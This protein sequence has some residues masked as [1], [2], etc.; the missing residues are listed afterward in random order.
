[1][2]LFETTINQLS[3]QFVGLYIIH[4]WRVWL[5][6]WIRQEWVD[7]SQN[8][9]YSAFLWPWIKKSS[10]RVPVGPNTSVHFI[11]NLV[12]FRVHP[13]NRNMSY[14]YG[15]RFRRDPPRRALATLTKFF[16]GYPHL[17]PVTTPCEVVWLCTVV[18]KTCLP[19]YEPSQ[20]WDELYAFPWYR[21]RVIPGLLK[22]LLPITLP[23][24]LVRL[25]T[26][27]L[28]GWSFYDFVKGSNSLLR[29]ICAGVPQGFPLSYTPSTPMTSP[30]SLTTSGR[31]KWRAVVAVRQQKPVQ[32]SYSGR[33][34]CVE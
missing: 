13:A 31:G 18:A 2:P 26:S 20:Q 8:G 24:A 15:C 28:N 17:L 27:F 12:S 16:N 4:N 29:S 10:E 14:G 1:M 32:R 11:L 30:H 5:T 7:W 19:H 22:K 3:I 6:K 25:M 21:P 23:S 33:P 9:I 34:R